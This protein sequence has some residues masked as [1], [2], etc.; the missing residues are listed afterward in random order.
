MAA[1]DKNFRL[2]QWSERFNHLFRLSS[3]TTC[4]ATC[5]ANISSHV[6]ERGKKRQVT[7]ANCGRI[8]FVA[9]PNT[10][11][12]R[13]FHCH[14]TALSRVNAARRRLKRGTK[15]PPTAGLHICRSRAST[16]YLQ[17]WFKGCSPVGGLLEKSWCQSLHNFIVHCRRHPHKL[18]KGSCIFIMQ[19]DHE[20][21]VKPSSSS[22][23]LKDMLCMYQL[24]LMVMEHEEE[25][26]TAFRSDT[27]VIMH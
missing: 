8:A 5:K 21:V 27:E 20:T 1:C 15:R 7:T 24:V 9:L 18:L 13:S 17:A 12:S 4:P 26:I 6:F 2:L 19:L 22:S 23:S 3:P 25:D 11:W 14:S 16:V 10:C